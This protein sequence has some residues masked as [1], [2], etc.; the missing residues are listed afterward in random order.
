MIIGGLETAF[1]LA[2]SDL[3]AVHWLGSRKL[4]GCV[5][6]V[7]AADSEACFGKIVGSENALSVCDF[8]GSSSLGT[9]QQATECISIAVDDGES[10]NDFERGIFFQSTFERSAMGANEH[11]CDGGPGGDQGGSSRLTRQ[12]HRRRRSG[13]RG[14]SQSCATSVATVEGQPAWHQGEP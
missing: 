4:K 7:T 6:S 14:V 3:R 9:R 1:F 12:G 10:G 8:A 13:P 11:A 5:T 2:D